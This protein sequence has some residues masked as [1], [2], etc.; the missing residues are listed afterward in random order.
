MALLVFFSYEIHLDLAEGLFASIWE[1]ESPYDFWTFRDVLSGYISKYSPLLSKFTVDS[2][3]RQAKQKNGSA[4]H[5]RK[6]V[7]GKINRAR[8]SQQ[9]A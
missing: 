9:Y 8:L 5:K 1:D 6:I 2:Q 4:R 3:M 7:A